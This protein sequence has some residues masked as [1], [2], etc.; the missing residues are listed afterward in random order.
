LLA[1]AFSS[2]TRADEPQKSLLTVEGGGWEVSSLRAGA[3]STLIRLFN[4]TSDGRPRTIR[5]NGAASKI[6]L[7]QLDGRVIKEIAA[8]KDRTGRAI[9]TLALPRL[10][11]GTLRFSP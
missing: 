1:V 6:V 7:V 5:Y 3:D 10:G 11:F 8:Q 9:F 2:E 4:A